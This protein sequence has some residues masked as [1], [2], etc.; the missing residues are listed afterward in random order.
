MSDYKIFSDC[1]EVN[2]RHYRCSLN[3]NKG[4][5]PGFYVSVRFVTVKIFDGV[6]FET[7]AISVGVP[8]TTAENRILQGSARFNRKAGE[9]LIPA[10]EK[11]IEEMI[12]IQEGA[13]Q[14]TTTEAV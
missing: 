7:C 6:S 9:K 10:A 11:A 1:R 4:R 8:D 3:Y 5:E 14:S 12:A 2:G 13:Y